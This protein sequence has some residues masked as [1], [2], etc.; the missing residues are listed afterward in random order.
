[1]CAILY[2]GLLI[3]SGL[4]EIFYVASTFAPNNAQ[5]LHLTIV[6]YGQLMQLFRMNDKDD[7]SYALIEEEMTNKTLFY[8]KK[9][10]K[11]Q[12]NRECILL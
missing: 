8:I 9:D 1:M 5:K 2:S 6:K 3:F 11:G 7:S 12:T 4:F 10:E